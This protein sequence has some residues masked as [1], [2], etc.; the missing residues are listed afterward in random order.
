MMLHFDG[1]FLAPEVQKFVVLGVCIASS[2]KK[3]LSDNIL[4]SFFFQTGSAES[5]RTVHRV[6]LTVYRAQLDRKFDVDYLSF[7]TCIGYRKWKSRPA[8]VAHCLTRA[9]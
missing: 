7:E 9:V 2:L 8:W 3:I 1:S 6:L 5:R 4:T